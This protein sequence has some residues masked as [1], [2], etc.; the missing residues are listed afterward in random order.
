MNGEQYRGDVTVEALTA[1][2]VA[3][4]PADQPR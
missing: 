4:V 3:P 2:L 1:A